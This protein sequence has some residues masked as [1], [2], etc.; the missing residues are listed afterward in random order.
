MKKL[1]PENAAL[2]PVGRAG[3]FQMMQGRLFSARRTALVASVLLGVSGGLGAQE[4]SVDDPFAADEEVER[5]KSVDD[6]FLTDEEAEMERIFAGDKE[7]VTAL[8]RVEAY[9]LGALKAIGLMDEEL[10]GA[11]LRKEMLKRVEQNEATLALLH[12]V[13]FEVGLSVSTENL[14]EDIYPTEYVPPEALPDGS[15]LLRP[16]EQLSPV[17]QRQKAILAFA[18]PDAFETK[19]LGVTLE[20]DASA[21]SM[22][23]G[24]WDLALVHTEVNRF[25]NKSWVEGIVTM[26][27]FQVNST[28]GVLR[29]KDGEWTM[30]S[31]QPLVDGKGRPDLSRVRMVLVNL[32]QVER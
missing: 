23:D 22:G 15:P 1:S 19:N 13:R 20:A 30:C 3:S 26:P 10:S 27:V 2:S 28:K 5:K 8:L 11:K 17:E 21:V 4:L 24:L 18:S 31:C 32:K 25:S 29:V 9:E 16:E 12:A 7:T 6:P 14:V